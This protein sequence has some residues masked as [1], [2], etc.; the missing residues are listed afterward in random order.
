MFSLGVKVQMQT[1]HGLKQFT[2]E[3]IRSWSPCYDPSRYLSESFIGTALDILQ[4]SEIPDADKL[5][6][7]CREQCI[8]AKTLRL[9]A[10]YCACTALDRL[11]PD[12]IDPRSIAAIEVAEK[13]ANGETTD[14]ELEAARSAAWSAQVGKLIDMLKA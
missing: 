3:D 8:D 10:C 13:F 12:Q 6:V 2:I 7:V 1:Q 5:W 11:A 4:H 14:Q 9:F